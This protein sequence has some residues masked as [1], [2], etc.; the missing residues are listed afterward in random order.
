MTLGKRFL[1]GFRAANRRKQQLARLAPQGDFAQDDFLLGAQL[2]QFIQFGL[3]LLGGVFIGRRERRLPQLHLQ[4]LG[5]TRSLHVARILRFQRHAL[6]PRFLIEHRFRTLQQ[7]AQIEQ[8][9]SQ[10]ERRHEPVTPR[11]VGDLQRPLMLF[12]GNRH[13]EPVFIRQRVR[14]HQRR[15]RFHRIGRPIGGRRVA[16]HVFKQVHRRS[17]GQGVPL[18]H[19]IDHADV[20]Q[21][22][23]AARLKRHGRGPG[24][25]AGDAF[26]HFVRGQRLEKIEP[27][28]EP[29]CQDVGARAGDGGR[30]QQRHRFRRPLHGAAIVCRERQ[31]RRLQLRHS[32]GR[33]PGRGA[34]QRFVHLR[35]VRQHVRQECRTAGLPRRRSYRRRCTPTR[36]LPE[37]SPL[38]ASTL[39]DISDNRPSSIR[40]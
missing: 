2:G 13:F 21:P 26:G 39:P 17:I 37:R 10:V 16:E 33:G 1:H 38:A 34:G 4:L 11:Q 40:A 6:L 7:P 24:G 27:G 3:L 36:K 12:A 35:L 18:P 23:R 30:P 28:A 15:Q 14:R 31:H 29:A 22:Q 20:E 19:R 9:A 8:P 32:L 5:A 25:V